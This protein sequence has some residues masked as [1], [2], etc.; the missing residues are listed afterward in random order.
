MLKSI[1]SRFVV[2]VLVMLLATM[3][4]FT[5]YWTFT[6]SQE[7]RDRFESEVILS[8]QF[9]AP[10][11]AGAVWDLDDQT[12][13]NALERLESLA[14]FQFAAVLTEGETF[15]TRQ[16]EEHEWQELWNEAIAAL[17]A[18]E[19]QTE[20]QIGDLVI[21]KSALLDDGDN[22]IGHLFVGLS[23]AHITH[24][25]NFLY[26][27]S[28]VVMLLSL[29]IMGLIT[30]RVASSVTG[31]LRKVSETM[32]IVSSGNFTPQI[33]ETGR[34]DEIGDI[35]RGLEIFS[36]NGRESEAMKHAMQEILDRA[37]VSA[38]EVADV[39]DRLGGVSN[40]LRTGSDDQAS[41]AQSAAAAVEEMSA[42]ARMA[43]THAEE[44]EQICKDLVTEADRSSQAVER[45]VST[46]SEVAAKIVVVQEIARQTDLLALNAAVEAARAGEHGK[47]FAVVASEVRKLAERSRLA[48]GEISELSGQSVDVS[49]EVS[50]ALHALGPSVQRSA[51]LIQEVSIAVREQSEGAD[52]ISESI[53][54][55][56]AVIQRN[57]MLAQDA[58]DT[59]E[60]LTTHSHSLLN[61]V[62]SDE[63]EGIATGLEPDQEE[64]SAES[65]SPDQSLEDTAL[66]EIVQDEDLTFEEP[67]EPKTD[68][69]ASSEA[70][71]AA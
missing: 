8:V 50:T 10:P 3:T 54:N 1:A 5:G 55:L 69:E 34:G 51:D 41:S 31:P 36:A 60:E 43:A 19:T 63:S 62:A 47:G 57:A 24:A 26:A 33:P 25:E 65:E 27:Q 29:L 6:H 12:A 40:E 18:D 2:P 9:L 45:A 49:K 71:S 21:V 20:T 53:S 64:L 59:S 48:A 16:R 14:H 70:R 42:N 39:S 68:A 28:V 22:T 11:L 67:A 56:E 38:T 66:D 4:A 58:A 61:L 30:R 32:Q 13:V 23:N 17:L 46:M 15:A 7:L 52:Q 44:T 37:S 35:A